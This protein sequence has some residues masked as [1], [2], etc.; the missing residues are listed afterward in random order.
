MMV[1]RTQHY[2]ICGIKGKSSCPVLNIPQLCA[3]SWFYG[4]GILASYWYNVVAEQDDNSQL[5]DKKS[6]KR[7]FGA[8]KQPYKQMR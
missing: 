2:E 5:T 3:A 7:S 6:Q 8:N 1:P 4:T